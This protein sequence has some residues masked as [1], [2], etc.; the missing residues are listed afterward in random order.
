MELRQ[1]NFLYLLL[2]L[3]FLLL[4]MPFVSDITGSRYPVISELAFAVF[5]IIGIWSLQ[6]SRRWFL[7]AI[8]LVALGVGGNILA[9]SGAGVA[10]IY[11]SLAGYLIFMMLTISIAIRQVFHY[12]TADFNNIIGAICIYLLLGVI[13]AL[14][15]VFLNLFI[16]GSFTGQI[17]GTVY[18][19][20]QDFLYYSF[21]TLT[22]LG[23]GEIVPVKSAAR[24]LATF[25][26][27][28]GQFYIAVLVAGLVAAYITRNQ[29]TSNGAS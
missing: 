19:Q 10:F 28:V 20:L 24:A 7:T 21:V 25:E 8:L 18:N 27:I 2:G 29:Q 3:M 22:T 4:A 5:L 23:Y 17:S 14:F 13:W 15:Y 11:L 26:A 1:H 9:L 6:G 16:P 12:G